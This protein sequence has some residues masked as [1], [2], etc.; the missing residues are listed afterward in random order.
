M[1]QLSQMFYKNPGIKQYNAVYGA[2]EGISYYSKKYFTRIVEHVSRHITGLQSGELST[3]TSIYQFK[4]AILF[5]SLCSNPYF[6]SR[7]WRLILPPKHWIVCLLHYHGNLA[8]KVLKE[9]HLGFHNV[10]SDVI[11]MIIS[12]QLLNI[13]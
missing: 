7:G 11:R 9:D 5:S 8:F 13:I 3:W 1:T 2:N 6:L 12:C 10:N 4:T